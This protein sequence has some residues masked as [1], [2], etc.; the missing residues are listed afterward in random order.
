VP[1]RIISSLGNGISLYGARR[2]QDFVSSIGEFNSIVV[3][4]LKPVFAFLAMVSL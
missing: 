4:M 2:L 1:Y 3:E